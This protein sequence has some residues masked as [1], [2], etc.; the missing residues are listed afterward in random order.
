MVLRINCEATY[1]DHL[2]QSLTHRNSTDGCFH[3]SSLWGS[4]YLAVTDSKFST[5]GFIVHDMLSSTI[6]TP[7]PVGSVFLWPSS[8]ARTCT[9]ACYPS[10]RSPAVASASAR[11]VP[12]AAQ[13]PRLQPSRSGWSDLRKELT[14]WLIT[15]KSSILT[16][17]LLSVGNSS[18][19]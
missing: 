17:F 11:A 18:D 19:E 15:Y 2:T 10:S 7:L 6:F 12:G 13:T 16:F 8:P 3:S 14:G 4:Q 1:I 5:R 9:P